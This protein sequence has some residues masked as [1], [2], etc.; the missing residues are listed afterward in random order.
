VVNWLN[1][2]KSKQQEP[3]TAD[4]TSMFTFQVMYLDY[5]GLGDHQA[6]STGRTNG[7]S[8]SHGKL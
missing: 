4:R 2:S 7:K 5:R 8:G 1:S 3:D 6:I